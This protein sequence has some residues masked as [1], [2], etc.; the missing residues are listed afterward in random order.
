MG[1]VLVGYVIRLNVIRLYCPPIPTLVISPRL[2]GLAFHVQ[3]SAPGRRHDRGTLPV[4][5]GFSKLRYQDRSWRHLNGFLYLHPSSQS[6][7]VMIRWL[8]RLGYAWRRHGPIG[9]IRLAAR[10]LVHHALGR[11]RS[12]NILPHIDSFDEKYG[13]DTAGIREI[14]SLDVIASAAARYAVRYQ[15]SS[16]QLVRVELENLN[17]DPPRF[18]FVDFGSGKGRVLFVAA[19]FPFKEVVGIEFS[20]ELHEIALRN[21]A[22]LPADLVRAGK[23]RS[24]H[25]DAALFEPPKSDLVCYFYNPFGAPV[26]GPVAERLVAHHEQNGYRVIIIYVDPRHR[27][28]FE[29]TGK[30][31][32]LN[33]TPQ[34]LILTTRPQASPGAADRSGRAVRSSR[35]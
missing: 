13:T 24:F 28:I 29:E 23:V 21:I 33:E 6:G 25:G 31:A 14:G 10:N 1:Y 12:V 20:R 35:I 19:G 22:R 9:F 27:K 7:I 8:A 3:R 4:L 18:T 34:T 32:I 15:P 17:I 2:P 11:D 26:M 5:A 16:A 30:F